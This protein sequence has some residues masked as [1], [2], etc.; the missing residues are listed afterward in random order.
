MGEPK[1]DQA[2]DAALVAT[3]DALRDAPPADAGAKLGEA[4]ATYRGAS[5]ALAAQ[6]NRSGSTLPADPTR[7]TLSK[8]S[9]AS[10]MPDPSLPAPSSPVDEA[11]LCEAPG[12]E[13]RLTAVQV[14]KGAHACSA[15]CRARAFRAR[16]RALVLGR[17]DAL[18]TE[19]ATLRA[20]VERW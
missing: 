16:R 15:S 7:T 8:R 1:V 3:A 20:E 10:P 2:L 12:C 6:L 11:P 4:L 18:A 9:H 13:V 17:L 14:A 5:D 19:L